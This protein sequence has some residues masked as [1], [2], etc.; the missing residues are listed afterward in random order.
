MES[1]AVAQVCRLNGVPWVIVRAISD[2]ADEDS[3][4]EFK[5][6]LENTASLAAKVSLG[7]VSS[8]RPR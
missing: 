8:L 6:N 1:A 5:R 3:V 2:S 4:A 7:V